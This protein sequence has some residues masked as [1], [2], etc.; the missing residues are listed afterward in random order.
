MPRKLYR[1]ATNKMLAGIC[2]GLGDYFDLDANMIRLIAVVSLFASDGFV[3]L[4]Y[5]IGWVIIP[6][7]EFQTS[8]TEKAPQRPRVQS[9]C[10]SSWKG[11][12]PGI[13][14]ICFG[15]IL[16]ARESFYWMHFGDLWPFALVVI[17]LGLILYRGAGRKEN[18]GA[19]SQDIRAANG[20]GSNG[21]NGGS[22]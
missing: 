7:A 3:L 13:L 10:C 1:S 18:R 20:H 9:A 15:L 11:Y 6:I 14:L 8:T 5:L 21:M 17:G 12:L 19:A 4:V 22:I 2:G 16:F